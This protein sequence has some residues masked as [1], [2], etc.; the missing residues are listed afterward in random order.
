LLG[1]SASQLL[2]DAK[3]DSNTLIEQL[4]FSISIREVHIDHKF[5]DRPAELPLVEDIQ[6]I[7]QKWLEGLGV[8]KPAAKAIVNRLPSYFVYALNQEWRR[9]AKSYRPLVGAL[10]T[11]FTKAGD[12]EWAWMAYSA[13]L[14]RKIQEGIFDEPFSLSQIYVPLNAFYTEETTHKDATEEMARTGRQRRR[15]VISLLEELE[16]WLQNQNLQDAIRVISGGPGSGKS[17]FARIFAARVS[18][19]GKAS[20]LWPPSPYEA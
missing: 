4:D 17:S 10:D 8:S 9:N 11:P 19:D 20:T 15:V 1:E 6:S 12:R 3:K 14:H 16:Q 18:Q 7:L 2:A 5:L 13:F